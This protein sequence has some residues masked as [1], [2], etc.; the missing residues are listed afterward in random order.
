MMGKDIFYEPIGNAVHIVLYKPE[1][2]YN[3]GNIIRL[4]A[5]VGAELHLIHPLGFQLTE[6]KLR[7]AALDYSDLTVVT[8]HENLEDYRK[9]YPDRVFYATSARARRYYSEIEFGTNDSYIFGPESSGITPTVLDT[10]PTERHL[11][12]PMKP[13]NRSLNI[14]NVVSIIAYEAWR[15][16]SFYDAGPPRTVPRIE[17]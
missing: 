5:N 3:T 14:A 17:N 7:R 4:C 8:E 1:I 12:I 6:A 9:M 15:Q 16:N 10:I 13:G 2:P 11:L